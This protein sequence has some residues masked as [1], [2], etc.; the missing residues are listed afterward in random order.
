MNSKQSF[1]LEQ[2]A[3]VERQATRNR[4][5]AAGA[6]MGALLSPEIWVIP[7]DVSRA[8]FAAIAVYSGLKAIHSGFRESGYREAV[9]SEATKE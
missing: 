5:A 7:E 8:S 2:A 4:I 9:L 1:L 6:T 3:K